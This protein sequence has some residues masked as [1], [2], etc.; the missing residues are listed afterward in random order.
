M[1]YHVE[2]PNYY[3]KVPEKIHRTLGLQ[4]CPFT[5]E[6]HWTS[7]VSTFSPLC[8]S[9]S[10][11]STAYAMYFSQD[12]GA[13]RA[14]PSTM[15]DLPFNVP[16]LLRS[17]HNSDLYNIH[18]MY[19]ARCSTDTGGATG[20]TTNA[21]FASVELHRLDNRCVAIQSHRN[22]RF[23]AVDDSGDCRFTDTPLSALAD[24]HKFFVETIAVPN[25]PNH[26]FFVSATTSKVLQCASNHTVR[27]NN[28]NRQAWESWRIIELGN[29]LAGSSVSGAHKDEESER[30]AW[31][32]DQIKQGKSAQEIR[33]FVDLLYPLSGMPMATAAPN[34]T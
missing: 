25:V 14:T 26:I 1:K 2:V 18:G 16:I 31:I 7:T 19:L 24:K 22:K 21:L 28:T 9:P 8:Y 3:S 6:N 17:Y 27:C 10:V 30:R 20:A 32:L 23:L 29:G 4:Y 34:A 13:Q 12:R 11:R 15:D 33:E 5:Y